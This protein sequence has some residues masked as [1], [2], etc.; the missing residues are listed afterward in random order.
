MRLGDL[1]GALLDA[2]FAIRDG[3]NNAKALFRQGQVSFPAL[4][5]LISSLSYQQSDLIMNIFLPNKIQL[6]KFLVTE[7][8][9]NCI[10]EVLFLTNSFH[11]FYA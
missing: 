2:D 9:F 11:S 8:L 5:L 3:E 6:N 7:I 1:K 4:P 10:H